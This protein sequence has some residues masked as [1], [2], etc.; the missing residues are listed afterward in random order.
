MTDDRKEQISALTDDELAP[1]EMA[2]LL[3][4]LS[5][6]EELRGAWSRYN[7]IGDVLRGE[8]AVHPGG[9]AERVRDQVA[10]EPAII[11]QP[12]MGGSET[13]QKRPARVRWLRP[14]AGLAAAAS[15]AAITLF[16]IPGFQG[17]R[18][19]EAPLR[20]AGAPESYTMEA[21]NG[22][23]WRNLS[24][25]GVESK[26]NRYLVEHSEYAA[27]AGLSGV[28]PYATF[29]SYDANR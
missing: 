23:R 29:V 5:A 12:A 1:R 27:P 7:L 24:H 19:E 21:G 17:D 20:L 15:V 18:L 2:E 6:N 22:T 13:A 10:L 9:M 14:A 26:L 8:H 11:A 28:M 16:N 4:S 3:D 25:P